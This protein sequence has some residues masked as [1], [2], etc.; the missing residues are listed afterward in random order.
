MTKPFAIA[1]ALLFAACQEPTEWSPVAG[2]VTEASSP[3]EIWLAIGDEVRVDS[4]FRVRFAGVPADSR[5][6]TSVV[7][8][9]AGDGEVEIHYAHGMGPSYPDTLHTTLDPRAVEFAGYRISLRDLGPYPND[10]D[11]IPP[12]EYAARLRIERIGR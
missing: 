6:P 5:C 11:P 4:I 12:D 10:A 8:P 1:A 2:H 3:I 9:W 7:C